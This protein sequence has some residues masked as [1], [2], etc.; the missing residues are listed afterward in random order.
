MTLVHSSL[1]YGK[2]MSSVIG[3]SRFRFGDLSGTDGGTAVAMRGDVKDMIDLLIS[4]G[5]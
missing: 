1:V 4:D 2:I 3:I 5:G